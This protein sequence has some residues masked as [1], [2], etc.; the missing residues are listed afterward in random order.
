LTTTAAQ[1]PPF[2]L[3]EREQ[4]RLAERLGSAAADARRRA[5]ATLAAITVELA[6][7]V[8]PAAVA[9]ASR[10]AAEPWFLFEQPDRGRRALAALGQAHEL[11]ASGP[12]RFDELA[13]GWRELAAR[14]VADPSQGAHAAGPI[15][16]GGLAFAPDGG[17]APHWRGFGASSLVV[18][19]VSLA[20]AGERVTM[21][22]SAL[23][24]PDDD[25]QQRA[26]L[27]LTRAAELR[28]APLPLL[29]PSPAGRF[30]V[31]SA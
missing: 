16:V 10:R 12:R 13:A 25:P 23:I 30:E 22:L 19:E 17:A 3:S 8:D 21:T 4:G 31:I 18:P 29:D 11:R 1:R 26:E 6:G 2:A 15:A 7:D 27:L 9:C 24:Q 5:C 28:E 14:A 20:R